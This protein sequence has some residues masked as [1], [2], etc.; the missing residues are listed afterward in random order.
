MWSTEEPNECEEIQG[1]GL[2]E[3]AITPRQMISEEEKEI[4]L[5]KIILGGIS[6]GGAT[7]IYTLRS[8]QSKLRGFV[9]LC[10]WR[11]W[12]EDLAEE[13]LNNNAQTAALRTPV[14]LSHSRDDE[15]VPVKEWREAAQ[16]TEGPGYD[17]SSME[18]I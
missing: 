18:G 2:E 10:S 8:R 1:M 7:A 9:G 12:K 3:S 6:Q 5:D 14:F 4:G 11:P 17:F 16:R 13:L 15:T